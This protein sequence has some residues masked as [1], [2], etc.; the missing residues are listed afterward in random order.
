MTKH[1]RVA[2]ALA[3]FGAA[4]VAALGTHAFTASNSVA[5]TTAG[6]GSAAISG[7]DVSNVNYTYSADGTTI[8]AVG[9]S[10]DKA[11]ADVKASLVASPG[12]ADWTDCGAS[13][14]TSPNITVSCALG[15]PTAV[16]SATKLSVLA[17]SSGSVT[18]AA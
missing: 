18:I 2:T 10:L 15:T 9:F 6:G 3:T 13:T 17:V 1:T 12:A 8:T 16:A 4:A 14:G 11:A 7:Y 5:A